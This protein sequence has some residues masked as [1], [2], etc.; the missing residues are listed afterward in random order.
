MERKNNTKLQLNTDFNN[1][2]K[3][4]AYIYLLAPSIRQA[5]SCMT[6]MSIIL[7]QKEQIKE[8]F[9]IKK[10]GN[11]YDLRPFAFRYHVVSAK[12]LFR[13]I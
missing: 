8:Y 1:F 6:L 4:V 7:T 2:I 11:I 13:K 9:N 3:K 10:G 12:Y 5:F